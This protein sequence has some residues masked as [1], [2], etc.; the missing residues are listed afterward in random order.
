MKVQL[1]DVTA[2]TIFGTLETLL[3]NSRAGVIWFLPNALSYNSNL[4]SLFISLN[5]SIGTH[6]TRPHYFAH[7]QR[8]FHRRKVHRLQQTNF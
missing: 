2:V 4:I 7:V 8:I 6:V 5:Y 3:S 1:Y